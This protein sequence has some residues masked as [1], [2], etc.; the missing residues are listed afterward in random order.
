MQLKSKIKQFFTPKDG[1]NL[2]RR[3]FI[4]D[5]S[6]LAA[7]TV[8]AGVAPSLI[9]VQDLKAQIASGAVQGQTFYLYEPAVIDIPGVIIADCEFIAMAPMPYMI[10][11]GPNAKKCMLKDSFIDRNNHQ[12]GACILIEPQGNADMSTTFQQALDTASTVHLGVG[13]H[14]IHSPITIPSNFKLK[15]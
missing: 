8:V 1:E 5:A 11:L 14:K 6:S 12:I 3:K 15:G 10:K 4:K 7:L 9:V 13:N 2:S